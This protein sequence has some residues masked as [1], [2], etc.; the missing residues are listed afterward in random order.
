MI[1]YILL[2]FTVG[3]EGGAF[4]LKG[5]DIFSSSYGPS[6]G[7][8]CDFYVT[9]NL[10]YG[11][12]FE[13]GKSDA[14][15]RSM[16]LQYDSL[17]EKHVFSGVRGE[18]FEYLQG[19]L[20]INW[21][22]FEIPISPYLSTRL[23]VNYWS[24]VDKEGDVVQSLN[25]NDFK[26]ISM[27]LGGGA[28]LKGKIAG[29]ILSGEASSNFIFSENRDWEEGFGTGDDNEWVVKFKLKLGKEF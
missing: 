26:G 14:S 29:F 13:R 17:G 5:D 2:S 22:P 27:V 15:T 4:E 9:P 18:N 28:G 6:F 7:A 23:G 16:V 12:S 24:F 19:N 21:I 10:I 11:L 8:F 3:L 20:S 1:F 25:G